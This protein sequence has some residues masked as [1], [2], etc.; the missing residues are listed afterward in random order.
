MS[1][2]SAPLAELNRRKFAPQARVAAPTPVDGGRTGASLERHR[3]RLLT[4]A[5]E[6]R[7]RLD[8][9]AHPILDQSCRVLEQR[10]CRIAVLGQIKAG[11]STFIN[12]LAGRPGLLPADINPW[13]AVVTLLQFRDA[14]NKPACAARFQ[15][16]SAAEWN[17]L[18]DGGGPLRELTKKLIPD[19]RP[20]LLKAQFELMRARAERRLG[21]AFGSYLGKTYS[22]ETITRDLLTD[23]ISAGDDFATQSQGTRKCL[24]DV[25]R[26]AELFFSEGP[27]AFPVTLIDTPGT[28]DPFLVR[29]EITRRSLENP[30]IFIFVVSAL[31]ALTS[32]DIAM[33]RLINGLQKDR[34][35]VFINRID[36]LS[37]PISDGRLIKHNVEERLKREF[38]ALSIPV[39]LGS[40]EWASASLQ[41]A[42]FDSTVA[43]KSLT[44]QVLAAHGLSLPSRENGSSVVAD[45]GFLAHAMHVAAG[46]PEVGVALDRLISTS[47][48]ASLLHHIASCLLELT[49][50]KE[51][52]LKLELASLSGV[53]QSRQTETAALQDK[54]QQERKVLANF[55]AQAAHLHTV[56][57]EIESHLG[58]IV[59]AHI[60]QLAAALEG[61][62]SSFARS[63][64]DALINSLSR[65]ELR[66]RWVCDVMPL[67]AQ[68]EAT[69]TQACAMLGDELHEL[70]EQIQPVLKDAVE[71]LLPGSGQDFG[72]T[73]LGK[74]NLKPNAQP[75][76]QTVVLDLS[77][78]WWKA[79]FAARPDAH[80]CAMQLKQ[81]IESDFNPITAELVREAEAYFGWYIAHTLDKSR[82]VAESILTTVRRRNEELIAEFEEWQRRG[83][84]QGDN[85]FE[86][87][88]CRR[89]VDLAALRGR[90]VEDIKELGGILTHLNSSVSA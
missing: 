7:A 73:A 77:V 54:I 16:F 23:Y 89:A 85:D 38:P 32:A 60:P 24:S 18:A 44:P 19:F 9:V 4:L 75:L 40:A 88:Q 29:D 37:N 66:S 87:R 61:I 90:M 57:D 27:F 22:F 76:R 52:A 15:M 69:Y 71:A 35:L 33:L 78:S 34:I 28:N 56:L 63:Q 46:L 81:L 36:Q 5:R 58:L 26:T 14:P 1:G 3:Q 67:R 21:P 25:T 42:T 39:V 80:D 79:W 65:Q 53:L 10:T 45:R 13:T 70:E 84:P 47:A 2:A 72:R 11:K 74:T 68:L 64:S 20:D 51:V 83:E 8:G 55:D 59:Q 6:L 82:A 49:K 12:A 86:T 48:S 43:A 62:V 50:G 41:T 31:Q 17:Q 30:D